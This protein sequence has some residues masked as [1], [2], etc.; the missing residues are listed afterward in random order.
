MPHKRNTSTED[1]EQQYLYQL[2]GWLSADGLLSSR[3]TDAELVQVA[4][5]LLVA[6][7]SRIATHVDTWPTGWRDSHRDALHYAA[8]I[9]RQEAF[10]IRKHGAE[11][12]ERAGMKGADALPQ[13]PYSRRRE[14]ELGDIELDLHPDEPTPDGHLP[15]GVDAERAA[16]LGELLSR[17][18]GGAA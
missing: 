8:T 12:T 4:E 13:P 15:A 5:H 7:A 11:V 9:M 18:G 10:I 3:V 16:S 6:A 2:L 14:L 1:L 17:L